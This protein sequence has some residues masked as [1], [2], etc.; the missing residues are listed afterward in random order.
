MS[1]GKVILQRGIENSE[2]PTPVGEAF[3]RFCIFA[4][5]HGFDVICAVGFNLEHAKAGHMALCTMLSP[6]ASA[7]PHQTEMLGDIVE[8]FQAS[9]KRMQQ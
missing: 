6:N 7:N 3:V 4:Q 9:L 1:A 5:Q 8:L 2:W